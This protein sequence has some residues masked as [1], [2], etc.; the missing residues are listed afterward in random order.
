[1][2]G[3]G[4]A[5][6]NRALS[7]G[8]NY[9]EHNYEQELLP[10]F[11]PGS[12]EANFGGTKFED[13]DFFEITQILARG[14]RRSWSRLPRTYTILRVIGALEYFDQIIRDK[15]TD[16]AIPYTK[17]NLPSCLPPN[18]RAQFY[19]A[20]NIVLSGVL[21]LEQGYAGHHCHILDRA[22]L[23]FITRANLA[24]NR[25][26]GTRVEKVYSSLSGRTFVLK[27]IRRKGKFY[28][29]RETLT[30]FEAE[31]NAAKKVKHD[32]IA[33]IAGSF[34]SP[35]QV[36]IVIA[37]VGDCDLRT[38]LDGQIDADRKS[39][40]RTWYGCLA[41][42]LLALHDAQIRHKDIK[43]ENIL[44]KNSKVF[45]TDFGI[46]LDWSEKT[47]ATT[48][49]RPLLFSPRFCSP[50]VANWDGRNES[51]DIWS[52][53]AVYLEMVTRLHNMSISEFRRFL[54]T[55][56]EHTSSQYCRNVP[57]LRMWISELQAR[58][59]SSENN[60]PLPWISECFKDR[61]APRP[62]ARK[63]WEMID[64]DT[65][66]SKF[67]YACEQCHKTHESSDS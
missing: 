38:F 53:G 54:D 4:Q 28:M 52:L 17:D 15:S 63:L 22:S 58:D 12:G 33:V 66:S 5:G 13:N 30:N 23:Q 40:L 35:T 47:R 8:Q 10:F 57:G 42:G 49:G 11:P 34:T 3:G 16:L 1:M 60:L 45:Y 39:L 59:S 7:D 44:I 36:G 67:S 55:H 25:A 37:T 48:T 56:G 9:T 62:T 27:T 24:Q 43:P 21:E 50:E 14:G 41:S 26:S 46:A 64:E 61:E 18:M 32:H 51:S 19:S 20:Q 2:F 65:Y 29:D 31:L 6:V